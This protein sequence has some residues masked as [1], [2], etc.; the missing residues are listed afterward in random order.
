MEKP[1]PRVRRTG[2][3]MGRPVKDVPA[4]RTV[5]LGVLV[6]AETKAVI[7]KAAKASGKSLSREAE[8]LIER[9]LTY[10]RQ[11]QAMRTSIDEMMAGNVE[12]T[13]WRL[14]FT[15][16]RT[17]QGKLWAPPGYPGIERS[18]FIPVDEAEP[19][20][21]NEPTLTAAESDQRVQQEIEALK[22]RVE[23]A[24]TGSEKPDEKV[25]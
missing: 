8:A 11:F 12:A 16:I 24:L 3:P 6:A 4:G 20:R 13:L 5:Q 9:A 1:K 14:G 21:A 25:A 2:R 17:P 19:P 15:P 23:A 10:D 18:G 22:R 7:A